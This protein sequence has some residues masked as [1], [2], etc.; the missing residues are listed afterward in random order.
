MKIII[1]AFIICFLLIGGV[2]FNLTTKGIALR[3]SGVI[4]PTLLGTDNYLIAHS[5]AL[6]LFPEFQTMKNVVWSPELG[7]ETIV[8]AITLQT[9]LE[10]KKEKTNV[11]P[12]IITVAALENEPFPE[13]TVSENYR[14]WI[15][16]TTRQDLLTSFKNTFSNQNFIIIFI[17]SFDRN[18]AFPAECEDIKILNHDCLRAAAVREVRKKLKSD[19]DYFF[20]RRYQDNEFY[21]FIEKK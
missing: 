10:L 17:H 19:S 12:E 13:L 7:L 8:D 14:W 2:I 1:S 16:P 15:L 20:M 5:L 21:L 4:K 9:A 6:R 11:S 3:S 18:E